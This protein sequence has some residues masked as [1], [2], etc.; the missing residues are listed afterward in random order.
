MPKHKA[1][2]FE[3]KLERDYGVTGAYVRMQKRFGPKG[4]GIFCVAAGQVPG[5][6]PRIV[7]IDNAKNPIV[8][9]EALIELMKKEGDFDPE[10]ADAEQ[11][12]LLE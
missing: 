11:Q 3:R 8:A 6:P 4:S 9:V 5:R 10:K 2:L 12:N 7:E 1:N